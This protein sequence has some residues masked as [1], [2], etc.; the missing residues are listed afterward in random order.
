MPQNVA[1]G[2]DMRLS[3]FSSFAISS[4]PFRSNASVILLQVLSPSCAISS[5][6]LS[7]N[8]VWECLRNSST[9]MMKVSTDFRN[10]TVSSSVLP[11]NSC[12]ASKFSSSTTCS[13]SCCLAV[14]MLRSTLSISS[15]KSNL[16][17]LIVLISYVTVR[18]PISV[19]CPCSVPPCVR[20]ASPIHGRPL[21]G[22]TGFHR[23]FLHRPM[24]VQREC[25]PDRRTKPPPCP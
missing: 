7:E 6:A 10:A 11:F 14:S 21:S 9:A 16:S 4:P 20:T 25:P 2:M 5:F 13:A 22:P 15:E 18:I 8:N 17:F 3:S 1:C 19:S 24:T 23:C 12:N